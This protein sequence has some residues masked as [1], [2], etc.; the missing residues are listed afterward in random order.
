MGSPRQMFKKNVLAV[1]IAAIASVSYSAIAQESAPVEEVLVTGIRASLENAMDIK[2]DA[3][4]VVDAISAEDIGKFPSTNLAESLQRIP[5]VSIN[6]V[7]G[8]G[9]Q[10][11]VRGFGPSFNQVTLNG[12]T[13]PTADVPI[14]GGGT[15][16]RGTDGAGRA[17]DFSNLASDGVKTLEVFK[18]GRADV[19]SGGIGAT[20]NVITRRP[21]DNDA[22]FTGALSAKAIADTSVDRG[23]KVTPEVGGTLSWANDSE[24]FGVSLF[25]S[26]NERHSAAASAT[27]AEINVVPY[28]G[29][30]LGLTNADTDITGAPKGSTLDDV[31]VALPRDSRYHFSEFTSERLNG[32]LVFEYAPSDS[33]RMAVDYTFAIN[34]G[35]ERRSDVS[36]W[37]NRPF[38]E[39]VFDQ[40]PIPSTIYL[41]EPSKNQGA[42]MQQT[43][44]ASKD[45]LNSF[46]FN[47][48]FDASD[49]LTIVL[50]AHTS[51]AEV[52]PN[53]AGG[54]S[55]INVG[56]DMK[57]VP[58]KDG[59]L[60]QAVN[61]SGDIPVQ[62]VVLA[63][64]DANRNMTYDELA[65][66]AVDPKRAS[67]Q[68]ANLRTITQKNEVDQFDLRGLWE[69][70]E[71]SNLTAG[72]NFRSQTNTTDNLGNRQILGDWGANNTGD[73]EE[74]VPGALETFCV[75][76]R[77]DDHTIGGATLDENKPNNI[78]Y[79]VRGNA[80]DIFFGL[81]DAYAKGYKGSGGPLTVTESSYD[82]VQE[83]VFSF[84]TQ[85]SNEFEIADRDAFLSLGLR[86][87]DTSV[88]STT[89][90]LPTARID[91]QGNNDFA[92]SA[93]EDATSFEISSS[94]SNFLPS[95]D[96]SINLTEDVKARASYS[97][98]IAR[99][100]YN[101]LFASSSVQSQ[102]GSTYLGG[103]SSASI[104][105]PELLPLES[106]NIDISVEW[107]FDDASYVSVGVFEKRVSNFVGRETTDENLFGLRDVTSGVE[108]TRSGNA[109]ALLKELGVDIDEDN[110]FAMTVFV[111]TSADLTTA[112]EKFV[113][114]QDADGNIIDDEYNAIESKYD[115][116][117]N[118]DDPLFELAVNR[119]INNKEAKINGL[120]LQGQH[121]FGDTGFGISAS[122]TAVNGDVGIDVAANPSANQFALTGLS[123]T[124]NLTLIYEAYGFS[125][126]LAYN[127]RDEFLSNS[128]D[129]SPFRNPIFTEAYSQLD[130][131]LGYEVNDNLSFS[132][133][134]INLTEETSR[135]FGRSESDLQFLREN[136]A[137]FMLGASYK[138]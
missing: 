6:R 123:D 68:V 78:V 73:S 72:V 104:G 47:A 84:Y 43:L 121:F 71:R 98:T 136:A 105:N 85:F 35:E 109:V 129:G 45:E 21:L 33:I 95:V 14:I 32:Q 114:V 112:K 63:T 131:S 127:W 80:E 76:C 106:D 4:G 99:A 10:I 42:A 58:T 79:G 29:N 81:T 134:A 120:E 60:T 86:Y 15:D 50:D 108:G 107:Y 117:A 55:R 138:F 59:T 96:F 13:L 7:N 93:A 27:Q 1:S 75:S 2:R 89:R 119:P 26:Y 51:E 74:L 77:F 62:T 44:R 83:D 52:S 70:D 92:T 19:A 118:G 23:D 124:A 64:T 48:E 66:S 39:V 88:T 28:Y 97:K 100:T 3:S 38:S 115:L 41:E 87:E 111:D 20:V 113:A 57:Y 54:Y 8:E 82:E 137:R 31:Y 34:E 94:Y 116:A 69:L 9:S 49:T 12:R 25:G 101:N 53:G 122:Y 37:F 133:D 11:T 24:T 22:G 18:T 17:F 36:N 128:N 65:R 46:G 5:G 126:R 103:K 135:E 16:G 132:F 30:F 102:A 61:Y 40:S 56:L 91:W 125:S 110:L 130:F 90:S 67:S